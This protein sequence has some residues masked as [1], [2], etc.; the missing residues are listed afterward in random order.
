MKRNKQRIIVLLMFTIGLL[1]L[2]YPF[3]SNW[4]N[5]NRFV[6]E[7][8][9]YEK[10]VQ[11]LD[12]NK[13]QKEWEK[14]N[15]YNNSLK[16]EPVKDPFIPG[17]GRALP[18]NYLE[19]LGSFDVMCAVEIP[20]IYVNLPVHHGTHPDTL[21]KGL[22]HIEGT[23]L[24]IGTQGGHSFITGHTGLPT[25]E[26]FTNLTKLEKGNQFYIKVLNR[27]LVYEV[28]QIKVIT[29]EELSSLPPDSGGDYVT[30]V[31]CTPYGINSHRLLVRG[32]RVYNMNKALPI[33][34]K[35]SM[36][37][38]VLFVVFSLVALLSLILLIKNM[39]KRKKYE[40]SL[41]E[42]E[43]ERKTP[44]KEGAKHE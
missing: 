2:L 33:N 32:T 26:L 30:L 19:V 43:K 24:P 5:S 18:T 27:E 20:S 31:T 13:L 25:A 21:K 16:G 41:Q 35:N 42:S 37:L 12:E 23:S 8:K 9:L 38:F 14:A 11:S 10:D 34:P 15:D 36:L 39:R 22:G 17:S 1:V 28:D 4:F 6:E 29:P 40:K 44:V 7:V 3:V